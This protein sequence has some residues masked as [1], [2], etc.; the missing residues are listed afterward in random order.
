MCQLIRN[1]LAALIVFIVYANTNQLAIQIKR[2]GDVIVH[3]LDANRVRV[4]QFCRKGFV[5]SAL[6]KWIMRRKLVCWM[7]QNA[8]D[9][10]M[11]AA[12]ELVA[13]IALAIVVQRSTLRESSAA[14]YARNAG[15]HSPGWA[16][17]VTAIQFPAI[18]LFLF[19]QC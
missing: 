15:N 2:S 17:D 7:W 14:I 8:L 13:F 9:M 12:V 11:D 18:L 3:L 1:H 16:V 10:D 4:S 19:P 6:N 5:P